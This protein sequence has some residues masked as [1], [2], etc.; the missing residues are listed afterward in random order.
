MY[1][2]KQYSCQKKVEVG[3]YH[4]RKTIIFLHRLK[5]YC[6]GVTPH[7]RHSGRDTECKMI[8][9]IHIQALLPDKNLQGYIDNKKNPWVKSG[10]RV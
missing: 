2:I 1:N 10:L 9:N 3:V 5:H 8:S 7:T 6:V 4:P